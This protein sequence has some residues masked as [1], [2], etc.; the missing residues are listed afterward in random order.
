[1]AV[2]IL[3]VDD[4]HG[5]RRIVRRLLEGALEV[6]VVGE[7]GD[8]EEAIRLGRELRPDVVLM[9]IHMPRVNGLEATRRIKG[10]RPETKVVLV[11]MHSQEAYR[12]T[13]RESGADAFLPKETFAADLLSTISQITGERAERRT[14]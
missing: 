11:S 13:A 8:G 12:R 2:T 7:A 9:D 14:I 3:I 5:F 1:M 4:H 10:E 6:R